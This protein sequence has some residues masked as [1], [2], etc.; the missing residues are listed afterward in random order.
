MLFGTRNADA[1][2]VHLKDGQFQQVPNFC[3]LLIDSGV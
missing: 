2:V 1:K 3:Q